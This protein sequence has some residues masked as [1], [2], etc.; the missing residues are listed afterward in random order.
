MDLQIHGCFSRSGR[1]HGSS[2][3]SWLASDPAQ[4]PM[5]LRSYLPATC[6]E[7]DVN[8]DT[9]SATGR[10]GHCKGLFHR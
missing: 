1:F 2:A 5:V 6:K 10:L 4:I 3:I 9:Y 7:T 8:H